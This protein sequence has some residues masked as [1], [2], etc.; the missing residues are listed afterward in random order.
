[1]PGPE[2]KNCRNWEDFDGKSLLVNVVRQTAM[3]RF[4]LAHG[5][6]G[7]ELPACQVSSRTRVRPPS[8]RVSNAYHAGLICSKPSG[9]EWNGIR[10]WIPD[11]DAE[12]GADLFDQRPKSANPPEI[13]REDG[14]VLVFDSD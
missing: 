4:L 11:D 7:C 14:S 6:S 5:A 2:T 9:S 8:N 3:S 10:E 13:P 12:P 1:M